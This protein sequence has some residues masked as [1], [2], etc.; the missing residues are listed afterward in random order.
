MVAAA[1]GAV[2]FIKAIDE[3]LI[4]IGPLGYRP[5][6]EPVSESI[7]SASSYVPSSSLLA[8]RENRSVGDIDRISYG[9]NDL[10]HVYRLP[11][12]PMALRILSGE[13]GWRRLSS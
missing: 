11:N 12:D 8:F 10:S 3:G 7:S 9:F 13:V 5:L 4:R 6:L 2:M 1:L